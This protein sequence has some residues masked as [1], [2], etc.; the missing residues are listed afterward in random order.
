MVNADFRPMASAWR[1]RMRTHEEWKVEIHIP[2]AAPPTSW[3][4]RSRISLAA[5]LVKVMARIWLGHASRLEM[6]LAMRRV[7][8]LVL[9][10]PAPA[11]MSSGRTAVQHGF[12]LLRVESGEQGLVDSGRSRAGV[13]RI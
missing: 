11:T 9:P 4:T 12:A 8:T 10:E 2:S 6:R 1:R 13:T 7:S 3:C 5:L